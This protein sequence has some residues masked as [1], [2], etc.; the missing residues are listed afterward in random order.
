[1]KRTH[2]IGILALVLFA[3]ISCTRPQESIDRLKKSCLYSDKTDYFKKWKSAFTEIQT[4]SNG[5]VTTVTTYPLGYFWINSNGTYRTLSD[6]APRVGK[7]DVTD[8]CRFVTD[9]GKAIAREF[10]V[11]KLTAD[12]L[13][14]K[15][16]IGGKTFISHFVAFNCFDISKL[17]AIW[18]N[19]ETEYQY[20]NDTEIYDRWVEYPAGY[21]TIKS[22][23]QYERLSNGNYL[24]GK[25][26]VD[27]D[28]KL[29]LDKGDTRLERSFEIQKLTNDSLVIW[30]KDTL[31]HAN[32]LQ[33]YIRH[34]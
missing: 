8:S 22:N 20:Y 12:S 26:L 11:V 6:I 16:Q 1:M 23:T 10:D 17:T 34:R 5:S 25:W 33:K 29:T 30:R 18:D 4:S 19:T 32:Y 24:A 3:A 13:V 21:F 28:C 9:P 14:L 31:A 2:A 27:G 15:T 7:W